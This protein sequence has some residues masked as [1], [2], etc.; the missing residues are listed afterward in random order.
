MFEKIASPENNQFWLRCYPPPPSEL[1]HVSCSRLSKK[2]NLVEEIINLTFTRVV[3]NVTFD[4]SC[5][6]CDVWHPFISP[7]LS[8]SVTSEFCNLSRVSFESIRMPGRRRGGRADKAQFR[9][10]A[11]LKQIERTIQMQMQTFKH[12]SKTHTNLRMSK[13]CQIYEWRGEG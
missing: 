4:Q 12:K 11:N 7:F 1:F 6:Q 2:F 3:I 5:D 10:W 13:N 9:N 8:L